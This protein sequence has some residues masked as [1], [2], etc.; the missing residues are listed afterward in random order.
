[1]CTSCVD[2]LFT[3]GPAPCPVAGC[4]KTLRKRGFHKAFFSDLKIER[5]VDVRK[6][7]GLVFNRREDEFETL[8]DWNNYLE[9]VEI[10]VFDIVEGGP[11]ER[12]AA[13]EELKAYAE[14]NERDI[15]ESAE[16]ER[17]E[18]ERGQRRAVAEVEAVRKRR[19]ELL[20]EERETKLE[21][22]RTREGTLDA[23]AR[24]NGNASKIT[25]R[26][27]K[28]ISKTVEERRGTMAGA[29]RGPGTDT[30]REGGFPIRGLKKKAGPVV[31]K[32]Y[33]AFGGIDLTPT[34]YVL[35]DEYANEWLRDAKSDVRHVA[36]GYSLKEY[37][38]RT[39][40]EAFSGMGVFIEDEVASRE[41]IASMGAT[42]GEGNVAD[43]VF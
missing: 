29:G 7:V 33:D 34:H 11:Q 22:Q 40:F 13:E 37:Y 4:H 26:A 20:K 27:L 1:M 17:E 23:L 2:R 41:Q 36:G 5:E 6:R 43:D 14:E 15:K 3:S 35:Q 28:A 31:E 32:P 38:S 8:R 25:E 39:M 42:V 9:K 16:A 12:R 24:G 18:K 10:L 19:E 21:L 30:S